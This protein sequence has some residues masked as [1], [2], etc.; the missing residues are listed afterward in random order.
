MVDGD[1][2]TW[3]DG[4]YHAGTCDLEANFT[5]AAGHVGDQLTT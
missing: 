3:P 5:E 4:R 2:V 1:D